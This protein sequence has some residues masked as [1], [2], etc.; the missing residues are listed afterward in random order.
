MRSENAKVSKVTV[1]PINGRIKSLD[2]V[3]FVCMSRMKFVIVALIQWFAQWCCLYVIFAPLSCYRK[4]VN[5][6]VKAANTIIVFGDQPSNPN[7]MYLCIFCAFLLI[8]SS[9][10]EYNA[11]MN[12]I[13]GS[14]KIRLF[15]W[16][17]IVMVFHCPG[18]FI[19]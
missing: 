2:K 10:N 11:D 15:Q 7:K 14:S 5:L 18:T 16:D 8:V 4:W 3:T 12:I 13:E 9:S 6:I 17:P 19:Q 1:L